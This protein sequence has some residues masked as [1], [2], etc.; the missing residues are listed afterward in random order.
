[1]QP[2]PEAGRTTLIRR[3][4][5]D[6]TGLPPTPGEVDAFRTDP[7]PEAYELLVDR[8]LA[9]PRYG[10]RLALEWL[11]AARYADTHGYHIDSGRDMTRWREWVIDAFNRN[12]PFDQFTIEQLPGDLLPDAT[13]NQKIAIGFNH[14]HMTNF[15]G[16]AIPED[17]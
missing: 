10:E 2:S 17:D 16:W 1:M 15:E 5:L 13:L 12:L 3:L 11:D 14:N 8:L 4:P 7:R 9:S 6:L